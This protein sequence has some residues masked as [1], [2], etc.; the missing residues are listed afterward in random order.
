MSTKTTSVNKVAEYIRKEIIY[1]NLKPGDQIKEFHISKICKISRV[2]V[3]EAL[4][5]LHSEGYVDM[6]PNRGS[7]VRKVSREYVK[8][9]AEVYF[10]IAPLLLKDAIP[11]FTS[12]TFRKAES[13]LR[14]IEKCRDFN[15]VGYLIWDFGKAIY[16]PSKLD[17]MKFVIN[18]I[19]KHN[20]RALNEIFVKSSEM[21]Y[22]VTH[23]KK[24][25]DLC[26]KKQTN[27]AIKIWNKHIQGLSKIISEKAISNN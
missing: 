25:L 14:K 4:R 9:V 13:I 10:I 17:F 15:K 18:E 24:F 8:E 16:G 19:Y 3:R 6:I 12:G 11:R 5:I 21:K 1:G 26:L 20:I 23:H 2:P 27:E 22:D 7:F